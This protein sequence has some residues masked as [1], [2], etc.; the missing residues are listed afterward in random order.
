MAMGLVTAGYVV[1]LLEA[2][3]PRELWIEGRGVAIRAQSGLNVVWELRKLVERYVLIGLH[4]RSEMDRR[5]SG[6]NESIDSLLIVL[7]E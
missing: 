1:S 6:V 7:S 3:K 4:S 5:R 2:P